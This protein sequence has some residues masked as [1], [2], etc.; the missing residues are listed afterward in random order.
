M[1][2]VRYH[3]FTQN[4]SGHRSISSDLISSPGRLSSANLLWIISSTSDGLAR[5]ISAR[6]SLAVWSSIAFEL[7]S[8]RVKPDFI[9]KQAEDPLPSGGGMNAVPNDIEL[10]RNRYLVRGP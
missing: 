1:K 6:I 2:L 10:E 5:K 7:A 8:S 9:E 4:I 3:H